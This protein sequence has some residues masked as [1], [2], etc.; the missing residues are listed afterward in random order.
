[1]DA[2][3]AALY[4][5]T[6]AWL[7]TASIG[8]ARDVRGINSIANEVA[9]DCASDLTPAA[10]VSGSSNPIRTCSALSRSSSAALGGA[11][12]TITSASHGSPTSWAPTS[13]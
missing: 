7:V 5:V 1:M 13:V 6:F 2:I 3:S 11:T 9:P 8:C 12:V 10:S 4:P